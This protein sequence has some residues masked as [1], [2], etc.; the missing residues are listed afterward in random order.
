MKRVLLIILCSLSMFLLPSTKTNYKKE[1][2]VSAIP[3][4][5]SSY[6]VMERSTYKVLESKAMDENRSVAS[7]SKVMTAIVAIENANLEDIVTIP[8]E[9]NE[10]YGSMLYIHQNDQIPLID[11]L[12]G[13]ILRSGN[14][15]AVSIAI[16][17]GGT[18][19]KF[20]EMMNQKATILNMKNSLFRNPHG[21]DEEDGGNL[22]SA[23]DMAL[24]HAYALNN[25]IYRQIT[26]ARQYKTYKNKNR[27]FNTYDCTTGG[28][29]GYTKIAKRTLVTSAMHD[30]LEL[31]IV[32]LNCG[33]DFE[34]HKKLYQNYFNQYEG[35]IVL[36]TGENYIDSYCIKVEK[37]YVFLIERNK[38]FTLVYHIQEKNKKV[39][40]DLQDSFGYVVDQ[41]NINLYCNPTHKKNMTNWN[42]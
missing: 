35:V 19:E 6:V 12:Y 40:I 20:V 18:I 24:L 14:D 33:N 26:S 30:D 32:T 29:T 31:V 10:V 3:I 13:L 1:Q 5:C 21:L 41:M 38:Q 39:Q 22:S 11:L 8:Q 9:I 28:K 17:V 16:H 27:L 7:I 4:Y 42:F 15:A 2:F 25:P 37:D 23:Y 36:K 34:V